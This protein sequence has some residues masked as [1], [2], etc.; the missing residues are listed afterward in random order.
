MVKSMQ[1]VTYI[2]TKYQ[3]GIEK[4]MDD[5]GAICYL[6]DPVDLLYVI[7]PNL[8]D[9]IKK[10]LV[11]MFGNSVIFGDR[12]NLEGCSEEDYHACQESIDDMLSK[13]G[14]GEVASTINPAVIAIT[15]PDLMKSDR[16][17]ESLIES[18]SRMPQLERGCIICK[19][20]YKTF[21]GSHE[22]KVKAPAAKAVLTTNQSGRPNRDHRIT[23]DEITNLK[24]AL[25]TCKTMEE[26]L[27]LV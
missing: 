14:L 21:E 4:F 5:A 3:G 11:G 20:G 1:A 12:W 26:F 7:H 2:G 9:E 8:S 6:P 13:I 23:V 18:F 24:I 10:G 16:R 17:I 19:D 15:V 22:R 25:E 27:S